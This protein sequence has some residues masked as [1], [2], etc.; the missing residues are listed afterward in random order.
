VFDGQ[1]RLVLASGT[2]NSSLEQILPPWPRLSVGRESH[3]SNLG[4]ICFSRFALSSDSSSASRAVSEGL[5]SRDG[6]S[7]ATALPYGGGGAAALVVAG[8]GEA[9]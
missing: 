2:D 4:K 9:P 3:T 1:P 8:M 7:P 5:G 6:Y